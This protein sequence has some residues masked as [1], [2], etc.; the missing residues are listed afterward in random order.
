MNR[1]MYALATLLLI[2]GC[3]VSEDKEQV[4]IHRVQV[5]E[6]GPITLYRGKEGV[7]VIR[8]DI[9][10]G[11]HVQANPAPLP[12][13]IPTQFEVDGSE[14]AFQLSYFEYP[15]G[16]PYTLEGS[17][18]TLLVYEGEVPIRYSLVANSTV[19]AGEY[20]VHGTVTYQ[21][22][23]HRMCFPPVK[24]RVTVEIEVL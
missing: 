16:I 9:K 23:D 10:E 18:D 4:I 13:L 24:E 17:P 22:C 6:P 15:E 19:Q 20:Q 12:Y 14:E 11:Y 5:Y 1:K 8:L 3:Q 7:G 2:L 21:T